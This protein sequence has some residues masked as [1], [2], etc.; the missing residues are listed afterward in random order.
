LIS[1]IIKSSTR[2][3]SVV[4]DPFAGSGTTGVACILNGCRFV[5][6]EQSEDYIKIANA[7]IEATQ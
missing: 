3:G 1:H 2:P 5:G 6:I 4:L 7:R